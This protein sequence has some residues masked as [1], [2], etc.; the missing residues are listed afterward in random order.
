MIIDA[1]EGR[2]IHP[3]NKRVVGDRLARHALAKTYGLGIASESPRFVSM[4]IKDGMA[5]LD[6]D[7]VSN[8]GLYAFDV[9][10]VRGFAMAGEDR[11]FK[12]AQAKIQGRNKVEVSHT[13][14]PNPVAVRYGWAD[15]PVVNLY[16]RNGLPVTPFRTDQW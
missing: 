4:E 11:Q 13:E 10:E 3:R 16:D 6:F 1:G 7:H 12:W 15:N 9:E 5:T 8:G 14:I 2:D